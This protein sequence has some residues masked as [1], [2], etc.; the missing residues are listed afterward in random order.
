MKENYHI[1][2]MSRSLDL[3]SLLWNSSINLVKFVFT[4]SSWR[5]NTINDKGNNALFIVTSLDQSMIF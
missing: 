4:P 3:I 2:A 1:H 5:H